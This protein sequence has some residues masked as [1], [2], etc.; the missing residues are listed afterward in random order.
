MSTPMSEGVRVL[1]GRVQGLV[2]VGDEK[3][4]VSRL[5]VPLSGMEKAG[6]HGGGQQ[7]NILL[8]PMNKE[9]RGSHCRI[10]M[11]VE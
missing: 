9:L 6:A 1:G 4:T 7:D 10:G 5:Q 3:R 2:L 11:D 8:C